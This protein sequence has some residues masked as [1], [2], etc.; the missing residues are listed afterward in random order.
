MVSGLIVES[1]VGDQVKVE[2]QI[3]GNFARISLFF[4]FIIMRWALTDGVLHSRCRKRL[5]SNERT[6]CKWA[7][8]RVGVG[9]QACGRLRAELLSLI[10]PLLGLKKDTLE[11]GL[12]EDKLLVWFKTTDIL[13]EYR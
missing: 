13:Q 11:N 8:S 3:S 1:A 7:T 2:L 9:E 6:S 4:F 10:W 5:G 12:G